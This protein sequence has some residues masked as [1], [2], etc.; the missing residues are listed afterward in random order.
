MHIQNHFSFLFYAFSRFFLVK[1]F[2]FLMRFR[3]FCFLYCWSDHG[4]AFTFFFLFVIQT[5]KG[6][7]CR[8]L[9]G[10]ET[11]E[12]HKTLIGE[13]LDGKTE[14]KLEVI[15][16]KKNGKFMFDLKRTDFSFRFSVRN[17]EWCNKIAIFLPPH[18]PI[19]FEDWTLKWIDIPLELN[20]RLEYTV[21]WVWFDWNLADWIKWIFSASYNV[22]FVIL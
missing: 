5:H 22:Q 11:K 14:L 20:V 18:S 1:Q 2:F 17:T 13:S 12:E 8:F 21:Y 19:Y 7:A 9:Y 16:Y 6:C 15:F 3:L 4:H 10:P